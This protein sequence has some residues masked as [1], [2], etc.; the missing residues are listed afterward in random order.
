MPHHSSPN[1][2]SIPTEILS[3]I[4]QH[5]L[6]AF[7]LLWEFANPPIA[8]QVRSTLA[9]LLLVSK[10][11]KEVTLASPSCWALVE[12]G[13]GN[14]LVDFAQHAKNE[15]DWSKES[16]ARFDRLYDRF[17]TFLARSK[18]V[19]IYVVIRTASGTQNKFDSLQVYKP[20]HSSP[21][22]AQIV[23]DLMQNSRR[24]RSLSIQGA[25]SLPWNGST[26][27][28]PSLSHLDLDG[29]AQY[30]PF[31]SFPRLKHLKLRK[32]E[33]PKRDLVLEGLIFRGHELHDNDLT[34]MFDSPLPPHGSKLVPLRSN[35]SLR[36]FLIDE[37]EWENIETI[38]DQCL[39][40]PLLQE[41]SLVL[42]W[43]GS[44]SNRN[45][46]QANIKHLLLKVDVPKSSGGAG[47][48]FGIKEHGLLSLVTLTLA[49]ENITTTQIL[50]LLSSTPS[51]EAIS[52][53][54]VIAQSGA[55]VLTVLGQDMTNSPSGQGARVC[56]ML[57]FLRLH[58][59]S[60]SFSRRG[61]PEV[62]VVSLIENVLQLRHSLRVELMRR[63]DEAEGKVQPFKR[64]A[65][66]YPGRLSFGGE[67]SRLEPSFELADMHEFNT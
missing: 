5:S 57:T 52:V 7:H 49:W 60:P 12:L 17:K 58:I 37:N 51:L 67:F 53:V 11:W 29:M 27:S 46:F 33:P 15:S 31:V 16:L 6:P 50:E 39:T 21:R 8:K 34:A 44:H 45:I 65:S 28:L 26:L 54:G 63:A 61:Q 10:Q 30:T 20:P 55:Q 36:Q 9:T 41:L 35:L 18:A 48:P 56:T 59:A 42:C 66:A 13:D 3:D 4:F 14:T 19:P 64:L 22:L 38:L 25:L 47:A 62:D 24:I 43:E 32:M 2:H 1:I 23:H 40:L